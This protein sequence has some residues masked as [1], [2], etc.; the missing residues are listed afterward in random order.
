MNNE[1]TP[2][3]PLTYTIPWWPAKSTISTIYFCSCSHSFTYM[4]HM[5]ALNIL[6][7]SKS[8]KRTLAVNM[9]PCHSTYIL[10]LYSNRIYRKL[11]NEWSIAHPLRF[12][13]NVLAAT[14]IYCTWANTPKI[15]DFLQPHTLTWIIINN[16]M[17]VL[18]IIMLVPSSKATHSHIY[19]ATPHF[20]CGIVNQQI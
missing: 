18:F 20:L 11:L 2:F 14:Y 15:H 13:A 3:W 1:H 8:A 7:F 10:R 19:R 5:P 9:L 6:N 4:L 16:I 12:S 17:L